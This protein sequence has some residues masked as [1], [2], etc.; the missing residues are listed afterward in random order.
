MLA[1]RVSRRGLLVVSGLVKGSAF[2]IW[3]SP[4]LLP[5]SGFS[6]SGVGVVFGPG[7]ALSGGSVLLQGRLQRSI[8]GH[9]RATVTSFA[10]M[11]QELVSVGLYLA[12]G[13]A[14]QA[15]GWRWAAMLFGGGLMAAA[16]LFMLLSSRSAGWIAR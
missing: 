8:N 15:G 3:L 10:G 7:F 5:E 16:A 13:V 11:L 1:D 12:I 4:P 2:L 6:L 9:A 14:A